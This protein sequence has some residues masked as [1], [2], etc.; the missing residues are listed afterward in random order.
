VLRGA[1]ASSEWYD[2]ID[3][4]HDT[5]RTAG[6]TAVMAAKA[7]T[8]QDTKSHLRADGI[9]SS[10]RVA[11]CRRPF[12]VRRIAALRGVPPLAPYGRREGAS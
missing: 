5:G 11:T 4:Q 1:S 7:I 2:V 12:R 6:A 10:P 9:A 8:L 3:V